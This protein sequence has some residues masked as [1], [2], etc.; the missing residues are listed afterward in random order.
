MDTIFRKIALTFFCL[1][2]SSSFIGARTDYESF[3]RANELFRQGQYAQAQQI[4]ESVQHKS[5]SA[6]FNLGLTY[7]ALSEPIKSWSCIRAAQQSLQPIIY[8]YGQ[9]V[10]KQLGIVDSFDEP[11]Y[12]GR[13]L[14]FMR[15]Y[16]I[17]IGMFYMQLL[18]LSALL[19]FCF[20][21]RI[22]SKKMIALVVVLSCVLGIPASGGLYMLHMIQESVYGLTK[23]EQSLYNG[24]GTAYGQQIQVP[25]FAECIIFDKKGEWAHVRVFSHEGW[26]RADALQSLN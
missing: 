7:A 11:T 3:V 4:Y 2:L 25:K 16:A 24:P 10:K 14:S 21:W 5:P 22:R 15:Q 18:F 19:L 1:L 6:L 9:Q 12:T 26:M 8:E 13:A 23:D 20:V 17:R